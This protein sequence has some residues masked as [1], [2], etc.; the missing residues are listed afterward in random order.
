MTLT[1]SFLF[2]LLESLSIRASFTDLPERKTTELDSFSVN[3]LYI[4]KLLVIFNGIDWFHIGSDGNKHAKKKGHHRRQE[5]SLKW[6]LIK[7]WTEARPVNIGKSTQRRGRQFVLS[8]GMIRGGDGGILWWMEVFVPA[9]LFAALLSGALKQRERLCECSQEAD[10]TSQIQMEI[11]VC[12]FFPGHD[13]TPRKIS[14]LWNPSG[15]GSGSGRG[16]VD[17]TRKGDSVPTCSR[18]RLTLRT[19]RH[20]W[21]CWQNWQEALLDAELRDLWGSTKPARLP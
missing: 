17:L 4:W 20:L 16:E 15:L 18:F 6:R 14:H 11:S 2:Y 3:W 12:A 8:V 13:P 1:G 9:D 21:Q 7:W 19:K 10:P 5:V